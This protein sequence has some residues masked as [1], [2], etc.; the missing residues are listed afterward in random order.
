MEPSIEQVVERVSLWRPDEVSVAPLPGGF[1]NQNSLVSR[2]IDRLVVR[3]AGVSTELLAVDRVNE[4]HNAQAAS[5]TGSRR[6]SSSTSR[7]GR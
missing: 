3:I 6:G 5:T 1:T 7:T 2:G 4:R